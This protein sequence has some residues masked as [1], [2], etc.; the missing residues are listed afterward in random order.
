M[1]LIKTLAIVFLAFLVFTATGCTNNFC[2]DEEM[3]AIKTE[4]RVML[5]EGT[6]TDAYVQPEDWTTKTEIQKNDYVNDLYSR[7]HPKACIVLEPT[8]D[9]ITGVTVQPKDWSFGFTRGLIEGVLVYPFSMTLAWITNLIGIDGLAQIIAII[10]VTFVVRAITML[11]S[12]KSTIAAQKMQMLQ[13]ELSSIQAKYGNSKDPA[14]RNAQAQ[15]M[16]ALY[17]KHKINPLSS[18]ISPFLTLPIFIAIYGAVQST[19]VLRTGSLFGV[20]LGQNLSVGIMQFNVFSIIM[21]ALMIGLQFLSMK[22]PGWLNKSRQAEDAR[23][24]NTASQQNTM[25]Y[26]F[27]VMIVVVGWVLPIAMTIYWIASSLFTVLQSLLFRNK[28]GMRGKSA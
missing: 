14:T 13:P 28:L 4:L 11:A 25:T 5:D 18:L 21:F 3:T 22:L 27:M 19:M 9:P 20:S 10:A 17:K 24:H 2:S 7:S 12:L 6:G 15:E 8:E 26:V 23:A 16:M 1:K